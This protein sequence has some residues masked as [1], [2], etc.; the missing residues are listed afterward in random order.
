MSENRQSIESF[1]RN[2][3]VEKINH[4]TILVRQSIFGKIKVVGKKLPPKVVKD[5]HP[6]YEEVE[7]MKDVAVPLRQLSDVQLAT[8]YSR[9]NDSQKTL[10]ENE[11]K[12]RSGLIASTPEM[13][14]ATI[15]IK[16]KVTE[17]RVLRSRP[18]IIIERVQAKT[19]IK[20]RWPWNSWLVLSTTNFDLDTP[21]I[22]MLSNDNTTMLEIDT[23]YAFKI[24]NP[25]KYAIE[26]NGLGEQHGSDSPS[27]ALRKYI[28]K[29]LDSIIKDYVRAHNYEEISSKVDLLEDLSYPLAKVEEQYGIEVTRFSIESIHPPKELT[30]AKMAEKTAQARANATMAEK[31]VEIDAM[32]KKIEELVKAGMDSKDIAN[33]LAMQGAKNATLFNIPNIFGG[34]AQ[35]QGTPS[36]NNNNNQNG[37]PTPTPNPDPVPQNDSMSDADIR[38]WHNMGCCEEDGSLSRIDSKEIMNQR[39]EILA[40][41]RVLMIYELTPEEKRKLCQ[42]VDQRENQNNNNNQNHR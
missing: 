23:D 31:Q 30:E 29:L 42:M 9:G 26:L 36:S 24:V 10:I 3:L 22:V 1:N 37:T 21:A 32:A 20:F 15:K 5:N 16:R 17:R 28:S 2:Y 11:Q 38:T 19:G 35:N 33:I 27:Q 41:G 18:D 40:P 8:L 25:K 4:G 12:Y 14:N 34:V 6:E 7:V 39:G 13:E